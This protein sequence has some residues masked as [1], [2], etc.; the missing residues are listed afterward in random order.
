MQ[1]DR[2]RNR[3][4][5]EAGRREDRIR[6]Q[7]TWRR[8]RGGRRRRSRGRCRRRGGRG[9]GRSVV[10]D[11]VDA[12]VGIAEDGIRAGDGSGHGLEGVPAVQAVAHLAGAGDRAGT[13]LDGTTRPG[14]R[15]RRRRRGTRRHVLAYL[16][17]AGI[18]VAERGVVA[19]DRTG[20]GLGRPF[21][22]QAIAHLVATGKITRTVF[23]G[24]LRPGGGGS[25]IDRG[26]GR[27]ELGLEGCCLGGLGRI[28]ATAA[29]EEGN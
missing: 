11:L 16:V 12:R 4:V 9:A 21:G 20:D 13:V 19:G 1:R 15:G 25:G 3:F 18:R 8:C 29:C 28:A 5:P 22:A 26:D 10:A 27:G 17:D 7:R 23:D 6:R 14:R 2:R 24:A